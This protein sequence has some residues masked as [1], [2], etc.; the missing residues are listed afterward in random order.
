[1]KSA[2]FA[3]ITVILIVGGCSSSDYIGTRATDGSLL[4][5]TGYIAPNLRYLASDELEGREATTQGERLASEYLAQQL[6]SYGVLPMGDSGTYFQNFNLTRRTISDSCAMELISGP[7]ATSVVLR[8][9]KDFL[10]SQTGY[11]PL[12]TTAGLVFAGYG[13]TAPE[14]EYDDYKDLNVEGKVVVAFAGEPRGGGDEKFSGEKES[15][16]SFL[17]SKIR[18]ARDHRARAL[19]MIS[20]G[21]RKNGWAATVDA[22]RAPSYSLPKE[23]P[24]TSAH[25]EAGMPAIVISD[26]TLRTILAGEMHE[27][28]DIS[29]LHDSMKPIPGFALKKSVHVRFLPLQEVPAPARNV[30]G[31]IEGS[32]P[33]LKEQYVALGAH[34]DH[35][36]IVGGKIYNGAD[37]DGS[38]T[39]TV[40]EVAR[41]FAR[42]KTNQRSVMVVFHTAEEKG[43][44]GSEYLTRHH[45]ALKKIIAQINL[46]M[47]GREHPRVLYSIGSR[48]LS[49]E[50]YNIVRVVNHD[51]AH[52]RLDYTFDAPDDPNNFYRRSDH[53]NYAKHGIPIVFFFDGMNEDYHQPSDD[54]EKISFAKL[55]R[56]GVLAY[57]IA[58]EIAN[59]PH[60]LVVDKKDE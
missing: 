4:I 49:N 47:V 19:L 29:T 20:K 18:N 51:K 26:S 54:V 8:A 33:L 22:Y 38:G 50:L 9:G 36:G 6:R 14:F 52:F 2:I 46:D 23:T 7:G 44:F 32:D 57:S 43:L 58:E 16:Y 56:V 17:F 41:A 45:P 35:V 28:D 1:M 25:A 21:A 34:Y 10:L 55:Q 48:R 30:V 37:D 60:T 11:S 5:D 15:Q 31:L 42:L 40:L 3:F 24:D 13:I 12:D 27:Y 39:V 59:L 53:Y